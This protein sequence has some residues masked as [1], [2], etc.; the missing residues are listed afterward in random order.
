MYLVES[1]ALDKLVLATGRKAANV[2]RHLQGPAFETMSL[3]VQAR[4]LYSQAFP[5]QSVDPEA[6]AASLQE[7]Q[8]ASK[9][10]YDPK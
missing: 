5:V 7:P 3:E 8:R 1:G 4:W 6:L 10:K 9:G 2:L